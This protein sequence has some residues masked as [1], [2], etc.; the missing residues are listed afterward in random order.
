MAFEVDVLVGATGF[1]PDLDMLLEVRLDLDP[2]LE[3]PS[4]LATLIDPNFHSCGTVPPHGAALLA[5][6][7]ENF[8]L[9]GSKSYGRAPTFLLATGYEQVRSIAAALSGDHA[10]AER[11]EL[12]LPETGVCSS[13]PPVDDVV[14]GFAIGSEHGYSGEQLTVIDTSAAGCCGTSTAADERSGARP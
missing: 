4:R 9:A 11:V 7:D 12:L 2:G 6:P 14:R 10:A 3:A 1:R 8:Y 13:N 5:H